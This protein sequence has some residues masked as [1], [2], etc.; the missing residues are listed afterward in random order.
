MTQNLSYLVIIL[1]LTSKGLAQKDSIKYN[2]TGKEHF[3]S[4]YVSINLNYSLIRTYSKS[5]FY[6]YFQ[7]NYN[8]RFGQDT[9]SAGFNIAGPIVI[10][11]MSSYNNG[12]HFDGH[13][14]LHYQFTDKFEPNDTTSFNFKAIHFNFALGKDI[15]FFWNNIDLPLRIGIDGGMAFLQYNNQG[16]RNPFLSLIAQSELR[17]VLGKIV[18]GSKLEIGYDI[19]SK[20]WKPKKNGIN[21]ELSFKNHYY[22]LQFSI[23]YNLFRAS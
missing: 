9:Y 15:L 2:N 21:D 23:G 16:N 5:S 11:S 10:G 6:E 19:T 12:K 1:L 22:S 13:T 14:G 20:N 8:S 17:F 3:T 4:N 7:N 18:L